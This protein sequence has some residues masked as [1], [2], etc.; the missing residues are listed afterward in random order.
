M[1]ATL[2]SRV[3]I[4]GNLL[5]ELTQAIS[6]HAIRKNRPVMKKAK[7]HTAI[8][9][10]VTESGDATIAELARALGVSGETVRR[11]VRELALEGAVRKFHGGV[12][13]PE[14]YMDASYHERLRQ[15]I[16][17]KRAIADA[18]ASLLSDG[19]SAML[20][21]GTTLSYVAQA[22]KNRNDLFV[23]TNSVDVARTLAFQKGNRVFMAGGELSD[24]DAC[25]LGP[26]AI[27][28]VERFRV[29]T[30]FI[31]AGAV[32]IVDQLM[33][34]RLSEA[35]FSNAIIRRADRVV[36]C[37][38]RTKMGRRA[39]VKIANFDAIDI[40]ITD[41]PLPADIDAAAR[42]AGVGVIVAGKNNAA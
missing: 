8:I 42:G 22:L 12:S 3:W 33:A 29:S 19:E 39:A 31:S 21:T 38:D 14:S 35:E 28:F 7:R 37:V 20:D 41:A 23:V 36:L 32:N 16:D 17:G 30:A 26:T 34:Y 4:F 40:L 11:D 2:L 25:A 10:Y 27:E 9:D 13:L 18:A 15:N 5:T 6:T 24:S 1:G